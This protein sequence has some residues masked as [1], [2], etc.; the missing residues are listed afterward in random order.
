MHRPQ[1]RIEDVPRGKFIPPHCPHDDCPAFDPESGIAFRWTKSGSFPATCRS[2]RT[3]RYVCHVCHRTFSQQTFACTY[4]LKRPELLDPVAAALVAGSAH[5]RIARHALLFMRVFETRLRIREEVVID[6]F[7]GFVGTQFIQLHVPTAVGRD[8]RY[9]FAVDHAQ[10]LG[11]ASN[12]F[13]RER[14]QTLIRRCGRP[15]RGQRLA[16][17]RRVIGRLVAR[18]GRKLVLV[19]DGATEFSRAAAENPRVVHRAYPNPKRGPKGAARSAAA[20]ERD[21]QM[22]PVDNLHRFIRH[23]M[24]HHRRETIAFHHSVNSAVAHFL[25]LR[26]WRN[27]LQWRR[28]ALPKEGTPAMFLGL[29]DRIWTWADVFSKRHFVGHHGL[30]AD[31]KAIYR[32]R[33]VTRTLSRKERVH[34]LVYAD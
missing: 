16:A 27:L 33:L 11:P 2:G 29:T 10:Q 34:H 26:V 5:R 9:L 6:M 1:Q 22:G 3:Q 25:L 24:A 13:Q 8:S 20:L 23:V 7:V 30:A 15:A 28:E 12:P 21:L 32:R 19:S 31:E 4:F 14:R 17:A 18:C